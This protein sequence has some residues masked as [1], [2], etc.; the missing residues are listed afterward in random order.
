MKT[1]PE[2]SMIH[3]AVIGSGYMACE[4][5]KAFFDILNLRIV[6]NKD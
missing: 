4:H 3:V 5:I 6:G 2:P 1:N